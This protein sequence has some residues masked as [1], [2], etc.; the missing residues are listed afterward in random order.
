[1]S[2]PSAP[3]AKYSALPYPNA[4][5]SSG[6]RAARVTIPSVRRAAAR[7]TTDSSASESS[8]TEPVRRYATVFRAIVATAAATES[9]A[10]LAR[11]T[12]PD[13]IIGPV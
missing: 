2:T 11:E 12:G 13:E 9:Q 7:F 1:M 10:N 6:G 8:P 3:L 5:S 4:C